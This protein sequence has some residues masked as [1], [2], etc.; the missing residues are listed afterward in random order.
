MAGG[1]NR[2]NERKTINMYNDMVR[3]K[4]KYNDVHFILTHSLFVL[5]LSFI[6]FLTHMFKINRK[7]MA[8]TII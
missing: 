7:S 5:S 4:K 3:G 6:F 8:E 2:E 1:N